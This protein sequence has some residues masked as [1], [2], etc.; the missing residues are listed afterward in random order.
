MENASKAIMIAASVLI[1][2]MLFS[3]MYYMFTR[4]SNTAQETQQKMA[5]DEIEAFNS[6]FMGYDTGSSDTVNITY[7]SRYGEADTIHKKFLYSE[8]FNRKSDKF[9]GSD[10]VKDYYKALLVI[11]QTLDTPVD[12]VTAINDAI[13]INYKNN[14]SYLYDEGKLEVQNSV[15]IIVDLGDSSLNT[16]NFSKKN[17]GSGNY[18]YLIIE[19][20][21]KV[22]PKYIYATN[23]L[24][25]SKEARANNYS[26]DNPVNVYS[27]LAELNETKVIPPETEKSKAEMD[28]QYTVYK[29]YFKCE[30]SFNTYTELIDSL[31]FTLVKDNKF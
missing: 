4:F 3:L 19:P 24:E 10:G 27:I 14:N 20:N 2:I 22:Q 8:V 9:S 12:L 29:Y 7:P 16:F 23:E 21:K 1:A 15:E 17:S 6:K 11:S 25:S 13:N 5:R 18:R 28:R 30:V 26:T 31:K